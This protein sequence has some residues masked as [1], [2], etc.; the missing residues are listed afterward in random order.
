[1]RIA[2]IPLT[3]LACALLLA[4]CSGTPDAPKPKDFAAGICRQVAPDVL[5]LTGL[6]DDLGKGPK[7]PDEAKASLRAAQGRL[8]ATLGSYAGPERGDLD[9]FVE[10][11]GLLRIRADGNT[12]EAFL[13]KDVK[14]AGDKVVARCTSG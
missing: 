9:G 11:V 3:L 7:V 5:E 14:A 4:G 8:V 6:V 13:T 12:Y 10:A 1:M 2:R